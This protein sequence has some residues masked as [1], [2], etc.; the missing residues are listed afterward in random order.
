M[1]YVRKRKTNSRRKPVSKNTLQAIRRVVKGNIE[2]KH[3]DLSTTYSVLSNAAV[4]Y[5]CSA[6]AQGD[7]EDERVGDKLHA[8][9]LQLDMRFNWDSTL[10]GNQGCR[11]MVVRDSQCQ[12]TLLTGANVNDEDGSVRCIVGKLNL[13]LPGRYKVLADRYVQLD[14]Y[15]P[16]SHFKLTKII[17]SDV[18][19]TGALATDEAKGQILLMMWCEQ[20]GG[21][22]A[23][24]HFT[25]RLYYKD[26]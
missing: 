26:A 21:S 3:S 24:V 17:N 5:N 16:T 25:R 6:I 2:S 22:Y 15:H 7:A 8:T 20:S 14:A 19:F 9:K 23:S 12:G 11:I 1:P 10:A 13:D 18:H 4:V